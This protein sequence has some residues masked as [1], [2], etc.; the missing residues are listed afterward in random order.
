MMPKLR[1]L[2]RRIFVDRIGV[3]LASIFIALTLFFFVREGQQES[4]SFSL[5]LELSVPRGVVQTNE[6]ARQIE[7]NVAGPKA[8]VDLLSPEQIGPLLVDLSPFGTGVSTYFFQK[9]M[10]PG[11]GKGVSITSIT[12]SYVVVRIEKEVS[13]KIPITV[14]FK[15]QPTHGYRID[16]S[17]LSEKEATL[18]GP[19]SLVDRTDFL[20]TAPFDLSGASQ[21]I[22]HTVPL[23]LPAP[24]TRLTSK[25]RITVTVH[26]I[27]SIIEQDI[28]GIPVVIKGKNTQNWSTEPASVTIKV[29]GPQRLVEK[30]SGKSL[31]ALAD[32]QTAPQKHPASVSVQISKISGLP[33]EI[34]QIGTL[35]SVKILR[36]GSKTATPPASPA[37]PSAKD[38]A[39]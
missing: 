31:Q 32:L 16:H 13:R 33:V 8:T 28:T 34:L 18:V 39:P 20:E 22:T 1:L 29:K 25:K 9:S 14:I 6:V 36:K 3:K 24:S 10:F 35:P 11:L 17:S 26:I 15:G 38:K 5:P 30:I 19:T 7:I 27:E 4:R 2:L 12:P 23:R 21:S 37:S